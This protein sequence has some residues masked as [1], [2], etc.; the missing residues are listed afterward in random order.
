MDLK[1]P[2]YHVI[3]VLKSS[4]P[5]LLVIVVSRKY[6]NLAIMSILASESLLYFRFLI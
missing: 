1:Q 6:T 4:K 5:V 3:S 2:S